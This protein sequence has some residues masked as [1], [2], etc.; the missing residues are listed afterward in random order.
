MSHFTTIETQ[1]H[2]VDALRDACAELNITV[3]TETPCRGYARQT[4]KADLT[5]RPPES[6]YDIAC[7]KQ[8]NES[9]ALTTDWWDGHVERTVGPQFGR[10]LQLYG[11]HKTTREARRRGHRVRRRQ[12]DDGS[13]QLSIS[14]GAA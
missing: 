2:D 14:G 5:L 13:I 1:V 3:L 11:V 6:P 8:V 10:L 4:R 9:Y 12:R 7:D